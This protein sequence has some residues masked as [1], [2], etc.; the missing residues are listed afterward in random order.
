MVKALLCML[1]WAPMAAAKSEVKSTA[2][3]AAKSS[4]L[5]WV[6]SLTPAEWQASGRIARLVAFAGD[7]D[8]SAAWDRLGGDIAARSCLAYL[9]RRFIRFAASLNGE[10]HV[11]DSV[12]IEGADGLLLLAEDDDGWHASLTAAGSTQRLGTW[13]MPEEH[14]ASA[15]EVLAMLRRELGYDAVVLAQK[16]NRLLLAAYGRSLTPGTQGIVVKAS[17]REPLAARD[18]GGGEALIEVTEV[19][20][21]RYAIAEILLAGRPRSAIAAGSKVRFHRK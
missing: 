4:A 18:S 13:M 3:P 2:K 6:E 19:A 11:D 16:D 1:L 5:A 21:T 9:P 8:R 14:R 7:A 20:G 17:A 12:L 10:T 15:T